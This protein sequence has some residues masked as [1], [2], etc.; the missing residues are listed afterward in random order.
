VTWPES[1]GELVSF[2]AKMRAAEETAD[3]R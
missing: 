2:E 3:L 1:R